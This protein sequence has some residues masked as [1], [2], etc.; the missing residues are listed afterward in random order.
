M[1][2]PVFEMKFFALKMTVSNLLI[3]AVSHTLCS[4]ST[5]SIENQVE[6][7]NEAYGKFQATKLITGRA[8]TINDYQAI[9]SRLT[10][11]DNLQQGAILF[12]DIFYSNV[13]IGYD[14]YHQLVIVQLDSKTSSRHVSLDT[15][16]VSLFQIS[17]RLY[18]KFGGNAVMKG[19][20]Y[21]VLYESPQ[22]AIYA[23]RYKVKNEKLVNSKLMT[24][25]MPVN[26]FYVRNGNGTFNIANKSHLLNSYNKSDLIRTLLKVNDIKFTKSNIEKSLIRFAHKMNETD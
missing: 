12:D 16:N 10:I 15:A 26:K 9:N 11:D 1:S 7:I 19:A 21:E 13:K 20:F 3:V 25:Y 6:S 18:R 14:L 24:K 8:Y 2:N 23:Y 4:Q 22:I 17:D 5:L